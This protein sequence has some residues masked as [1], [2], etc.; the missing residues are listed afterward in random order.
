M[1]DPALHPRTDHDARHAEPVSVAVDLRG[2]DMVVEA[3]PVVPGE[4]DGRGVPVRAAHHRVDE[5]GHVGLSAPDRRSRSRVLAREVPRHDPGHRRQ[6]ARLGLADERL[7]GG[8]VVKTI[9]PHDVDEPR[10]RALG[11]EGDAVRARL[12]RARLLH[13]GALAHVDVPAD[14][15]LAEEVRDVGPCVDR[16]MGVPVLLMPAQQVDVRAATHRV[17]RVGAVR[18]PSGEQEQ[19]RRERPG[20]RRR[21]HAVLQHVVPRVCPVV[22]DLFARV[23]A[24]DVRLLLRSEEGPACRREPVCGGGALPLAPDHGC[25]EPV[26]LAVVLVDE[27]CLLIVRSALLILRRAVVRARTVSEHSVGDADLRRPVGS[28]RD[29][30]RAGERA[31]VVIERSILLHDDDDVVDRAGRSGGFARRWRTAGRGR[32]RVLRDQR[33]GDGH[34]SGHE[35]RDEPTGPWQPEFPS[36]KH[37]H[38]TPAGRSTL[39]ARRILPKRHQVSCDPAAGGPSALPPSALDS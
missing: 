13:T 36:P 5:P 7:V 33:H 9:V 26:H 31:E 37:A 16:G 22:R 14:A 32:G 20:V 39:R 15:G 28:Q 11:R 3:A 34:R 21:E 10:E 30:V 8:E 24:E 35:E 4:V 17:A 12:L 27:R 23:V 29:P 6:R 1:I 2:S 38:P 25:H 19:V 18:R